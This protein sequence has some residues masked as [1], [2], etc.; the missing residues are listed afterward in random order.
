M[1]QKKLR[2]VTASFLD[3]WMTVMLIEQCVFYENNPFANAIFLRWGYW[4]LLCYKLPIFLVI[5]LIVMVIHARGNT[6]VASAL[7]DWGTIITLGVV[8][9]GFY[10]FITR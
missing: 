3:W 10:L 1:F 6:R 9:Y 4:G 5:S 8:F 7:L 2:F